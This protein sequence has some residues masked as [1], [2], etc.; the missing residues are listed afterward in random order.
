MLG[1]STDEKKRR[2]EEGRDG[3][4]MGHGVSK[5]EARTEFGWCRG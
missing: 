3:A 2:R 4:G 5:D 1:W